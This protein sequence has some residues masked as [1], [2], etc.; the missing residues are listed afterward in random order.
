MNQILRSQ[1]ASLIP[2]DGYQRQHNSDS[3]Q[4][5]SQSLFLSTKRSRNRGIVLSRQGWQKLMQAGALYDEFGNRYTY[6]Q[7]SDRSLLDERTI[8]RL[9][10]CEVKVDKR[11][12]K[13]FFRAFN[14]ILEAGDYTSS[15]SDE[16]SAISSDASTCVALTR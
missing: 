1:P 3:I 4:L 11:T 13:T 5:H 15:K 2:I 14:L 12:L 9:L 10:S 8:N 6:E 16:M 7:L